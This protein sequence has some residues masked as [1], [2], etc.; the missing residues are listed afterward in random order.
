MDLKEVKELSDFLSGFVSERRLQ[1]FEEV[2]NNRLAHMHIVIE[3][4]FQSH[5]ASAVLRSCDGFGIQNVHFI[6]NRNRLRISDDVA[7]G[8][9]QW[10]SIH[11]YNEKENNSRAAIQKLKAEGYRIVATSPH[12]DDTTIDQLPVDQKFAL[13]FGT[14]LDGL[15]Q[16]VM[17]EADEFVKIP[18]LGFTE[19]FNISVCAA[20]CMYELSA[21]I[22]KDVP[23]PHLTE[24]EKKR[25]YFEWLKASVDKSDA[26]IR[27]FLEDKKRGGDA[28]G[29]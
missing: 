11:R 1:R 26:L 24:E 15:S 14:E 8:S 10:L 16:E 25:V 13:I 7:L 17:E 2:L 6:E 29:L 18:M 22:R 27:R 4:L 5:N 9:S 19:S 12:K 3:N 21:R 28:I 20:M 23:N